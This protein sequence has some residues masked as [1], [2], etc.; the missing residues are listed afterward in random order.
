MFVRVSFP[1]P[2]RAQPIRTRHQFT[3]S[4]CE[5]FGRTRVCLTLMPS[6]PANAVCWRAPAR[7]HWCSN[8]IL[9][10]PFANPRVRWTP[11]GVRKSFAHSNRLRWRMISGAGSG[12]NET[13]KLAPAAAGRWFASLN[14]TNC[15][16][17]RTVVALPARP[18][19]LFPLRPI[20][21]EGEG[22]GEVGQFPPSPSRHLCSCLAPNVGT[23]PPAH[24]D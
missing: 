22:Q 1:D 4:I 10:V 15:S 20:G 6:Q 5:Q 16:K 18:F 19:W 21:W 13:R 24:A 3:V 11:S 23:V 14:T 7:H 17:W 2:L 9:G 12:M 8:V